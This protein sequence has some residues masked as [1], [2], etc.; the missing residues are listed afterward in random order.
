MGE[1]RVRIR[2]SLDFFRGFESVGNGQILLM[3]NIIVI[4]ELIL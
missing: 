3:N 4:T 1:V 2:G